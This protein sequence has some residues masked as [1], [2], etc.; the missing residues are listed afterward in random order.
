MSHVTRH[1]P[2]RRGDKKENHKTQHPSL[3]P[4]DFGSGRQSLFSHTVIK[5]KQKHNVKQDA[6]NQDVKEIAASM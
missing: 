5:Q 2:G 1:S 3:R 6:K 4:W